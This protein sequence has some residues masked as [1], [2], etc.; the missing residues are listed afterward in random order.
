MTAMIVNGA[1]HEGTFYGQTR[2]VLDVAD[3]GFYDYV[4]N[5]CIRAVFR[6]QL[7]DVLFLL[8]R[9]KAVRNDG[10]LWPD[11]GRVWR[12]PR[13]YGDDR[14]RRTGRHS[15]RRLHNG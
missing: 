3:R 2:P 10:Y 12:Q 11:A 13:I 8:R 14:H 6:I 9:Y 7:H 5:G 4:R 1:E 15:V